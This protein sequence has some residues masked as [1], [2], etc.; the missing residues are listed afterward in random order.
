MQMR[1][2]FERLFR[3][4]LVY[5]TAKKNENM[6]L[7]QRTLAGHS[8]SDGTHTIFEIHG[9]FKGQV[10]GLAEIYWQNIILIILICVY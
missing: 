8:M 7:A 2:Y 6:R 1:Y 4:I 10:A 5:R 9:P 3:P